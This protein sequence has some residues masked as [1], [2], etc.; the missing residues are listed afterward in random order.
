MREIDFRV[1]ED[2]NLALSLR[3]GYNRKKLREVLPD[4]A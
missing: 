1:P 3:A 4:A 2:E